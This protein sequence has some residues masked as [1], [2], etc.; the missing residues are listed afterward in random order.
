MNF[1]IDDF[2]VGKTLGAGAFGKVKCKNLIKE[3]KHIITDE[4]V[5]IKIISNLH[6]KPAEN[7][8]KI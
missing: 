1:K 8:S 7:I 6:I 2:I 3:A 5:A 4:E